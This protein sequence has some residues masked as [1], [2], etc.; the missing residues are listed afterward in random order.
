MISFLDIA[1]QYHKSNLEFSEPHIIQYL[2]SVGY[3]N[4]G[5]NNFNPSNMPDVPRDCCTLSG[6]YSGKRLLC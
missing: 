1:F 2:L 3:Q 5:G 4:I 6:G